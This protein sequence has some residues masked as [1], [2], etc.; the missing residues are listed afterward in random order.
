MLSEIRTFGFKR[1]QISKDGTQQDECQSKEEASPCLHDS[2]P[3]VAKIAI[4]VKGFQ[5]CFVV[6]HLLNLCAITFCVISRRLCI[7]KGI[8]PVE[9]KNKKINP[10]SQTRTY[11][12]RK[13]IQFLGHEPIIWK[14]WDFK[15]SYIY[16][17]NFLQLITLF[18]QIFM[19]RIAKAKGRKDAESIKRIR[20]NK[21]FYKLDHIVKER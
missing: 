4:A 1:N 16:K 15:V 12:L 14:F 5:V 20:E 7:I 2:W 8:Y 3:G 21:P 19:K 11:Y 17:L 6:M 18:L 9:P 13:D 10:T